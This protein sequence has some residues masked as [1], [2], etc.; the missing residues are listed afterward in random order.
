MITLPPALRAVWAGCGAQVAAV[1]LHV[2]WDL[3]HGTMQGPVLRA[4]HQ[5][6]RQTPLLSTDLA[7]GSLWIADLGFFSLGHLQQLSQQ[8]VFWLS[9]VQAGTLVQAAHGQP[10]A[11]GHGQSGNGVER[12]WSLPQFVQRLSRGRGEKV[13][14]WEAPVRLGKQA[15]VACRLLV[16]RVPPA[17]VAQRRVR[18]NTHASRKQQPVTKAQWQLAQWTLL[19]TNVPAAQLNLGEAW[20]LYRARWQIE[21]LFRLWKEVGQVDEWRSAQP[22]RILCEVYAKLLAQVVLHWLVLLGTWEMADRSLHKAALT[23]RHNAWYLARSLTQP[24]RLQ[25]ALK[26]M[27]QGLA[28]GC[29][30]NKRRTRPAT[31]QLLW[32]LCPTVLP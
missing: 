28:C 14:P 10:V 22:Y 20:V 21:R 12:W 7:T 4:A 27:A 13:S 16:L 18:L 25:R 5:Q 31:H 8:Q 6:D 23:V 17:V 3:R 11:T 29:R 19:V 26:D 15:G 32:A 30:I 24:R 9:R 2:Q 1:K